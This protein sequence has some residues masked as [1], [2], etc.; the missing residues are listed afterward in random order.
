M[1]MK[2]GAL[3]AQRSTVRRRHQF[4]STAIGACLFVLCSALPVMAGSDKSEKANPVVDAAATV[5]RDAALRRA[6]VWVEPSI[7]IE[8]VRFDRNPHDDAE[9]LLSGEIECRFT[10]EAA[11]GTSSKFRCVLPSG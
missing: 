10:A 9:V 6:Q 7:P 2:T 3:V 5:L 11:N 4:S 8:Q 1:P